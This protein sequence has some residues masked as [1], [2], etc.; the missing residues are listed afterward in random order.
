MAIEQHSQYSAWREAL[1]QMVEAEERYY[2]ALMEERS[3]EEIQ[4]AARDLDGAR[5]SYRAIA[6]K[7]G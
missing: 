2:I 6:D 5:S 7:I 4:A 3:P 1:Q